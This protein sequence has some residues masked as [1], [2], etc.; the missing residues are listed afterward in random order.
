MSKKKNKK[1]QKNTLKQS[2][3]SAF[4]YSP[5]ELEEESLDLIGGDDQDFNDSDSV[6]DSFLPDENGDYAEESEEEPIQLFDDDSVLEFSDEQDMENAE[7]LVWD[8]GEKVVPDFSELRLEQNSPKQSAVPENEVNQPVPPELPE[9]IQLFDNEESGGSAPKSSGRTRI[10]RPSGKTTAAVRVNVNE[11]ET[12][13]AMEKAQKENQEREEKKQREINEKKAAR[14]HKFKEYI[15]RSAL[16]FAFIAII[17][18]AVAFAVYYTFLLS[19]IAVIGNDQ[20]SADY[21]IRASGLELGK[22]MFF[23]D[24][25]AAKARIEE[26]PYLQVNDITYI[27]PSH[28]RI[29]ITER[30]EAAGIIG[31]DYNVIIDE[32]GYVLSMSGGTDISDLLQ[33]T[34][35]SMTGFQL[36]QRVGDSSDFATSTMITLIEK[37]RE[38][39]LTYTISTLD[40]TTPLAIA[41]Y[42]PSGFKIFIG[43]PTDLDAKFTSL[44]SLLPRLQSSGI[45]TGTLYLSAKNGIVYSPPNATATNTISGSFNSESNP[46]SEQTSGEN[47]PLTESVQ[48]TPYQTPV[49]ATPT[50]VPI[51]PGGGDE[52]QG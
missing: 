43:Q 50:P 27:F 49:P 39:E 32:N 11:T 16:N 38:Y 18:V 31:L 10:F 23:V 5:E 46:D 8:N 30:K 22:H 35:I 47:A 28:V 12:I 7:K 40:M 25:D 4:F 2:I 41:M 42:T 6:H 3:L 9:E 45:Q 36:G 34:G 17:V 24:L 15:K 51:Q 13:R 20:Y 52:F 29:D 14:K 26:D 21:I 48:P 1:K 44:K 19:D 33:I 37:I